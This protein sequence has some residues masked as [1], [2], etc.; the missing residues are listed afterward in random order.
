MLINNKS[1]EKYFIG[2]IIDKQKLRTLN[3]FKNKG[4]I[5]QSW[6]KLTYVVT[7]V[8]KEYWEANRHSL[9]ISPGPEMRTWMQSRQNRVLWGVNGAVI[10]PLGFASNSSKP[11]LLKSPIC[12]NYPLDFQTSLR[13][14]NGAKLSKVGDS[15]NGQARSFIYYLLRVYYCWNYQSLDPNWHHQSKI[16]VQAS[17]Q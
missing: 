8:L 14:W 1:I 16:A 10:F 9:L 5:L 12:T 15:Q 6:I 4:R 7:L 2:I 13:P 11:S 17:T 3:M